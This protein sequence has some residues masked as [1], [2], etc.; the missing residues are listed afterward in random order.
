M[1]GREKTRNIVQKRKLKTNSIWRYN[2]KI[3]TEMR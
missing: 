1:D 3:I 2:W